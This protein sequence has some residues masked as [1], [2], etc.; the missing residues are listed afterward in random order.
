M[1]IGFFRAG[2]A[3]ALGTAGLLV[4]CAVVAAPDEADDPDRAGDEVEPLDVERVPLGAWARIDEVDPLDVERVPLPTRARIDACCRRT[5][6]AAGAGSVAT[7]CTAAS[8]FV[9]PVGAAF[10]LDVPHAAR[11]TVSASPTVKLTASKRALA[12]GGSAGSDIWWRPTTQNVDPAGETQTVPNACDLVNRTA[13]G[14]TSRSRVAH[15]MVKCCPINP[16]AHAVDSRRVS[17]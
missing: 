9:A 12:R 13:A 1:C 15:V 14:F 17:R 16:H 7:V 3:T 11:A 5:C 8:R 10:G 4:V 6:A 2:A